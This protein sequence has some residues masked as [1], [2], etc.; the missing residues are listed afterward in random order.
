MERGGRDAH[1]RVAACDHVTSLFSS[2]GNKLFE[3]PPRDDAG[4]SVV[5]RRWPMAMR[6]RDATPAPAAPARGPAA[7]TRV[8]DERHETALSTAVSGVLHKPQHPR[9][10]RSTVHRTQNETAHAAEPR[11]R[12]TWRPR[13]RRPGGGARG[14]AALSWARQPTHRRAQSAQSALRE[15][16]LHLEKSTARRSNRKSV[17]RM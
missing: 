5:H 4:C 8:D 16:R 13:A 15:W 12:S 7:R 1:R 3:S 11:D 17:S 10:P 14:A 6:D 2:H 9:L